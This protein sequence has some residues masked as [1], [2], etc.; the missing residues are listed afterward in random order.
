MQKAGRKN[1]TQNNNKKKTETEAFVFC[2]ITF[3]PIK[4]KTHSTPQ[5]DRLNLSFLKDVYSVGKKM[6]KNGRKMTVYQSQ[7]LVISL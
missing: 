4:I 1:I 5:N 3:E 6:T 7:I 2:I